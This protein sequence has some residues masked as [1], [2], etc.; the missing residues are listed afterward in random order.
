MYELQ[1]SQ[2]TTPHSLLYICKHLCAR[3]LLLYIYRL[4]FSHKG[5]SIPKICNFTYYSNKAQKQT[6]NNS[7]MPVLKELD[8]KSVSVFLYEP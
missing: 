7:I 1:K 6:Y 5:V 2:T 4:S 3:F 8:G